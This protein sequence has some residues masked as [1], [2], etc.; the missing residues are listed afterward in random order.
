VDNSPLGRTNTTTT[1]LIVQ[2]DSNPCF[3]LESEKEP[4]PTDP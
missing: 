1:G 3:G 4:D 2:R